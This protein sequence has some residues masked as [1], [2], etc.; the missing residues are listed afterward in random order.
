MVTA[1]T[2]RPAPRTW[3][4]APNVWLHEAIPLVGESERWETAPFGSHPC[5][6]H[7]ARRS[8]DIWYA[9]V[10]R[11]SGHAVD[12]WLALTEAQTHAVDSLSYQRSRIGYKPEAKP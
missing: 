6:I 1:A 10:D 11:G 8:N 4:I 5:R 7:L 9:V 2:E 12:P 3:R